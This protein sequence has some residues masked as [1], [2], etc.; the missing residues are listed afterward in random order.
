MKTIYDCCSVCKCSTC[1]KSHSQDKNEVC[2][3]WCETMCPGNGALPDQDI[4]ECYKP[5]QQNIKTDKRSICEMLG[6]SP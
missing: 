5:I 6:I 3:D 4:I 1:A 2:S